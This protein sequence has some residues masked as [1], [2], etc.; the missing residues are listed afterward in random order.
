MPCFLKNDIFNCYF[1]ENC[2]IVISLKFVSIVLM[3]N[4]TWF[5]Q[6]TAWCRVGDKRLTDPML[7]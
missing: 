7:A 1:N 4:K 5:V 2:C 3:Y 6:M